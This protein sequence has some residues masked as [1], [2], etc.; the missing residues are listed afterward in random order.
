M[1]SRVFYTP[2][3]AQLQCI[4]GSVRSLV[5]SPYTLNP[6]PFALKREWVTGIPTRVMSGCIG[7]AVLVH[8]PHVRLCMKV[9]GFHAVNT[10]RC[11]GYSH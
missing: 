6:K 4:R 8:A 9:V 7:T 11:G 1:A 2:R 5:V 10:A 3:A